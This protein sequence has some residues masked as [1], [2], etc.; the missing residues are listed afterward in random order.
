MN[1]DFPKI[2]EIK[3]VDQYFSLSWR[4]TLRCN[5]DCMYCS[6]DWHDTTSKHK[7]LDELKNAWISI[8][9]KTKHKN[10]K[11]KIS[12]TGGEPTNNKNLL[13][14][15][16]W[17]RQNYNEHLFQILLT[18]NGSATYSYYLKL[19]QVIDNISFSTHSE[20]FKEQKFFDMIC[21]LQKTISKDKFLFVNLMDEYWNQERL[22]IYKKI[23]ETNGINYAVN[24]INYKHKIREYPV[25][26]GKLDL[27]TTN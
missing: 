23:L 6:Y 3:P 26:K 13:P 11:Y 12:L 8:F 21:A 4:I 5:Y 20:F 16:T 14:F 10:L 18:S 9:E 15:L 17:L 2:I 19:F 27:D 7:S 22:P 1:H 25:F 24:Q